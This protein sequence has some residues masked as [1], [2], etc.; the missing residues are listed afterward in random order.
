MWVCM[1]PSGGTCL[2]FAGM[3]AC[4]VL[5]HSKLM[6]S[7]SCRIN[8][9]KDVKLCEKP[10]PSG[11]NCL[12]ILLLYLSPRPFYL[13]AWECLVGWNGMK[14]LRRLVWAATRYISRCRKCAHQMFWICQ[15]IKIDM[16]EPNINLHAANQS[17]QH[18]MTKCDRAK[19]SQ[20]KLK[21]SKRTTTYT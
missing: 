2:C 17:A 15:D 3:K 13:M 20:R 7:D 19:T 16:F 4:T 5:L 11:G 21:P 8:G 9:Y 10:Y 6:K 1:Q 18:L 14:V 12:D